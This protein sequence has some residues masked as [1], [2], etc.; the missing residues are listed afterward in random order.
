MDEDQ[1]G[2]LLKSEA[3]DHLVDMYR[4]TKDILSDNNQYQDWKALHL[5]WGC[6][7]PNDKSEIKKIR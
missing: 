3:E 5:S 2:Y 1:F 4:N 7:H 6:K